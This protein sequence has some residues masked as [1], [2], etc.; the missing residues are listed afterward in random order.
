MRV[1]AWIVNYNSC[2]LVE[3]C[4]RSLRNNGVTDAVVVDNSESTEEVARLQQLNS[5]DFPIE[6]FSSGGNLGYG[7]ALNS[8]G[9]RVAMAPND[10]VCIL[11]PDT[12]SHS[13]SVHSIV[14][15]LKAGTCDIVSPH[16]VGG[17]MSQPTSWF[18]GG[19]FNP[20]SCSASHV[21]F[22]REIDLLGEVGIR[23]SQFLSGAAMLMARSTW[24]RLGG[25]DES[26]F[27]YWED[28][29]LSLR[30]RRLGMRLAVSD[31]WYLWH[32]E[33]GTGAREPLRGAPYYRFMSEN[34]VRL[35]HSLGISSWRLV[36]G[37]GARETLRLVFAPI[38]NREPRSAH[39]AL[40]AL[41]GTLRG[42]ARG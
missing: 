42:I 33:G 13:G 38:R 35:A 18:S 34:R 9:R 24:D 29:E 36:V 23:E 5:R 30:A 37:S 7:A 39:K 20:V 8:I 27:M 25:F 22:G 19:R 15:A 32:E 6:V 41:A 40:T 31:K 14:E 3:A 12:R 2:D 1:S 28:V 11:N 21:D 17:S 4:I 16:I 10:V 26:Y